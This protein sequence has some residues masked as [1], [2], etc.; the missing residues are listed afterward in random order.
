[1]NGFTRSGDFESFHAGMRAPR[2]LVKLDHMK[3]HRGETVKRLIVAST[4]ISTLVLQLSSSLYA[5]QFANQPQTLALKG[6][7]SGSV[8]KAASGE[9]LA[10]A[11]VMLTS[12]G[13]A[14]AAPGSLETTAAPASRGANATAPGQPQQR[15][16]PVIIPIVKTDDQGK[17]LV[18]DIPAG[19]YRVSATRNG[20]AQQQFGQRSIGRPGTVITVSAG[21][22]V[23]DIAFRLIPAGT[24][25]GRV[26]DTK[27]EPLPGVTV[28]ALRSTYDSTGKRSLRPMG[29]AKT[30]DLGEYRLYWMNPGRYFLN[31]NAAPQGIEALSALSS[32]AAAAQTP[33]TPEEAQM[34]AESQMILGPGKNPNEETDPGFVM[35]YYPG[36]P[37]ASRAASLELQPGAE[38]RGMDFTLTRDRKVR[39]RGKIVDSSTGRPPQ[40]AQVSVASRDSAGSALDMLGALGGALQGNTYDSSTGEFEIKEVA[41]GGYFLQ[42]MSQTERPQ[43]ADGGAAAPA[44]SN[45]QIPLDV[46]GADIDNVVVTMTPGVT[47]PGRVRLEGTP[48]TSPNNPTPTDNP[49]RTFSIS[50]FSASGG[51]S[52]MQALLGGGA[53]GRP[54]ADG[55]FSL[56]R[57][58]PGDYKLSVSGLGPNMFIKEARLDQTDILGGV[59]ISDRVNG[60]LEV[61]LSYNGGIVEGT[62][63]DV[64][65]KPVSGVQAVLIPS[66]RD[67]RELYK[68]GITDPNG[69]ISLRGL[70]PGDYRLFAWEDIEPFSYFDPD[71]LKQY[72]QQGKLVHVKESATEQVEMKII[73]APAP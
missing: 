50:F 53:S 9:V 28:Q 59:K 13:N 45:T 15:Q 31:A 22:Q 33:S 39:I 30:N 37:D 41:S 19:S 68:T 66:Q 69:K 10:G 43:I 48:A 27:G 62:V 49:F 36:T 52:L 12:V 20:Y 14:P 65:S 58:A 25:A 4:L 63:T 24:I 5:G 70:T 46:F 17:F 6:S 60:P 29:T 2:P 55:T 21:Q 47:I 71:V 35:T 54:T 8:V 1:M 26:T 23:K 51:G 34:M 72:E 73:P 56:Q 18:S 7:I 32:R 61:T 64:V 67:R 16:D 42:V 57:V 38:I 3:T 11:Q 40:M 44:I